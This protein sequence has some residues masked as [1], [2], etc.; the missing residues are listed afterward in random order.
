MTGKKIIAFLLA[1]VFFSPALTAVTFAE[2]SAPAGY[3]YYEDFENGENPAYNTQASAK[4]RWSG[5][6]VEHNGNKCMKYTIDTSVEF[7]GK[8]GDAYNVRVE[9]KDRN[10]PDYPL[11]RDT[12]YE[13]GYKFDLNDCKPRFNTFMHVQL[14]SVQAQTYMP[15]WKTG[16][17][18]GMIYLE[19]GRDESGNIST[20]T[21]TQDDVD[22]F[23]STKVLFNLHGSTQTD[24]NFN[25]NGEAI[26]Y[27]SYMTKSGKEVNEQ[28]RFAFP[29]ASNNNSEA[30]SSR[31]FQGIAMSE[32][33]NGR[34]DNGSSFYI[35]DIYIK[36]RK[37]YTVIFD[38]NDGSGEVYTGKSDLDGAVS[39]PF[40]ERSGYQFDGWYTDKGFG[41]KFDENNVTEDIRVYAKWL[42]I[43]TVTFDADGGIGAEPVGTVTG[44]IILP[45][46]TK[47]RYEFVGWF[48]D[49]SLQEEFDGTGINSDMTV[50]AKWEYAWEIKFEANGGNHVEPRYAVRELKDIPQG[51]RTG[52]R[53]DGWFRDSEL[54]EPFDGTGIREDITVYAKWTQK[55]KI[56]FESNG[57]GVFEPVYTLEDIDI[58]T[59]PIPKKQGFN[60]ENWYLDS[61]FTKIF[62]GNGID[63][64][65]VLYAKYNNV[66]F[67]E[68]FE[69]TDEKLNEEWMKQLAPN[70][71]KEFIKNGY[72]VVDDGKGNGNKAFRLA[73][74][75]GKLLTIPFE[76]G[77]KGLYEV[78]FKITMPAGAASW[79]LVSMLSPMKGN[80]NIIGVGANGNWMAVG[81]QR[82]F[83]GKLLGKSEGY[84]SVIYR[85]DTVNML[86]SYYAEYVDIVSEQSIFESGTMLPFTSKADTVD[87]LQLRINNSAGEQ[88]SEYYLDDI[89]VK[90][91][92]QPAIEKT[93]PSENENDVA[94]D[95]EIRICF[96][97]KIDKSTVNNETMQ[98]KDENGKVIEAVR[99][100]LNKNE[101]TVVIMNPTKPLDYA[102]TYTISVGLGISKGA[103]NIAMPYEI[104]FKTRPLAL[105]YTTQLTDSETQKP[106]ASLADAK[107]KRVK[108]TLDIRNYAG[109]ETQSFLVFAVLT[110]N[111]RNLQRAFVHSQGTVIKGEKPQSVSAEFDIPKN[112]DDNF[113]IKFYIWSGAKNRNVL[114]D[115]IEI[116]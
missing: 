81:N 41:E 113:K 32:G 44:T 105:E 27:V 116:P 53:F 66:L 42:K 56:S 98:L 69:N 21:V 3:L 65:I 114:T 63:K 62:D 57:G 95:T 51:E 103:Y 96:N 52:Y 111:S 47:T 8:N 9:G 109:N 94:L 85:V 82:I 100:I 84:V 54:T 50:Y 93:I 24:S 23:I 7:N 67:S 18:N 89:C 99:E 78:S 48:K 13:I 30:R 25:T 108:A 26:Y 55:H 17:N 12:W 75:S 59:L 60:F 102:K 58:D 45:K 14:G 64:D 73:W 97:D 38:K 35:D 10:N 87:S 16:I 34:P 40:A 22:G 2:G 91:I 80:T 79:G 74:D 20:V 77:G 115:S 6:L 37:T 88:G 86:A 68:D 61:K 43:H 70:R 76:D 31:F 49:R 104:K 28:R 112:A 19:N 106:I 15:A 11:D 71:Y 83:S 5:T 36:E 92:D 107:G 101:K 39:L 1:G 90:K 110:D 29:S 72:G 33:W 4:G 46:P